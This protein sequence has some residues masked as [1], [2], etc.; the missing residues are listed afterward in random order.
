MFPLGVQSA[1]LNQ[2]PGAEANGEY[3]T[4]ITDFLNDWLRV[5]FVREPGDDSFQLRE[6][7]RAL[8]DLGYTACP[9]DWQF[10]GLSLQL[11]STVEGCCC[12]PE[13]P[14]GVVAVFDNGVTLTYAD[15]LP[16]VTDE[17]VQ[18]AFA[19]QQ[20]DAVP[21]ETYSVALHVLD[22]DGALVAQTDYGLPD[23]GFQ[24]VV[25]PIDVS[26]LPP[27]QYSLALILYAWQTGER[28]TGLMMATGERDDTLTFATF[29]VE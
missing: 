22:A 16:R 7:E 12:P 27:G 21:R 15:P 20:T 14:S 1:M 10:D 26:A 9:L 6:F 25:A 11:Y 23:R 29:Q 17:T 13:D 2:F 3:Y 28:V 5:W 8:A 19:W 4:Q 24:C 18:T